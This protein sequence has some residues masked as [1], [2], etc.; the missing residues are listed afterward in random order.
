MMDLP[1]TQDIASYMKSRFMAELTG[2]VE[3]LEMPRFPG[4]LLED[5]NFATTL[6]L[7]AARNKSKSSFFMHCCM[8]LPSV[9]RSNGLV[10]S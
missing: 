6:L 1:T 2:S 8:D 10:S 7:R 4:D 5:C 9:Y 3:K